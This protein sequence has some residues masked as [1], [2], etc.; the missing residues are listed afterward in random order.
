MKKAVILFIIIILINGCNSSINTINNKYNQLKKKLIPLTNEGYID[1]NKMNIIDHQHIAYLLKAES[2]LQEKKIINNLTQYLVEHSDENNDNEIGW[3]L[4]E[5]WDAFGDKTINPAKHAYS[6][7]VANV[8]DAYLD[9]LASKCLTPELEEKVKIQLHDVVILW[10][11]K[12]WSENG[13]HG[14]KYFYWYSTSEN[15]AIGTINIDAKMIGSQARLLDEYDNIFSKEEKEFILNHIDKTYSKIMEQAKT[16]D[17][18]II[19]DY[20]EKNDK[21]INDAIHHGFILEG[22]YDYQKYRLKETYWNENYN[23]YINSCIKDYI[24]FSY[25][26]HSSRRCFD[27]GAIKWITDKNLQEKVLLKSFDIYFNSD[28]DERQL[29]FLLDALSLYI[30][31]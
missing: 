19:W 3:G 27:T 14:E 2:R 17:G 15:D 16:Q 5:E 23:N 6:I 25:A 1:F 20:I 11:N 13:K 30:A 18:N 10:N 21:K 31:K 28:T 8:V 24:I 9:A 12:Y 22:I 7:E 4:N 26:N 29:S